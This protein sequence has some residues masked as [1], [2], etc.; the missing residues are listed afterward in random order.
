M[1]VFIECFTCIVCVLDNNEQEGLN[2]LQV[3]EIGGVMRILVF[4]VCFTI[5]LIRGRAYK[6]GGLDM[7]ILMT[8]DLPIDPFNQLLRNGT[9]REVIMKV[10]ED[11][12]PEAV[13]FSENNEFCRF[14]FW[15]SGHDSEF[16]IKLKSKKEISRPPFF[17]SYVILFILNRCIR[18]VPIGSWTRILCL[19]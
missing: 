14:W 3:S 7:R 16:Y 15:F 11:I 19:R 10:L 12:K 5:M 18:I 9:E 2:V 8:A 1:H 6:N 17:E 13:Y 4:I